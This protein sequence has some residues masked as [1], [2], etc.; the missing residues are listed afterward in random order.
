M[1]DI[2]DQAIVFETTYVDVPVGTEGKAEAT[3]QFLPEFTD[4]D[5]R[6]VTCR[7]ARIGIK[8]RG[9]LTMIHGIRISDSILFCT[10]TPSEIDNPSALSLKNVRLLTW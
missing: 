2:R 4:I 7:D 6:R 9:P 5:I 3:E 8:A 1:S 10:E